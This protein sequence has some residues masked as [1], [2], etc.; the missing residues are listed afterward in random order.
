MKLLSEIRAVKILEIPTPDNERHQVRF[1]LLKRLFRP[2]AVMLA[3][4]LHGKALRLTMFTLSVRFAYR[5][6]PGS[7]RGKK[8]SLRGDIDQ[9]P[10]YPCL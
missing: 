8:L 4:M 9:D 3:A 7:P 1:A 5:F 10:T 2:D 6:D